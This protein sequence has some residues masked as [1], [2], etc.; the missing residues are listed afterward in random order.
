MR[1]TIVFLIVGCVI[2]A[3]LTAVNAQLAVGQPA[4]A[5]NLT[6]VDG[7]AY[8]LAQLKN[9]PMSI[10]FFFD[11]DSKPSQEGLI[12][13]DRLATQYADANMRAWGITRSAMEKASDF[14][15]R[16]RL[17]IPILM[18]RADVSDR[19]QARVVLPTVCILGPGQKILDFLQGGGTSTQIMLVRW[20]SAT[21]SA[22]SS[23]SPR[24]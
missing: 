22:N 9:Q 5:F 8:D 7:K 16:H 1:W 2:T 6:G 19:Y 13:L 23:R 17:S 21:C 15:A 12:S 24:H 18:D 14:A 10:L 4:P 11:V 20:P 3:P